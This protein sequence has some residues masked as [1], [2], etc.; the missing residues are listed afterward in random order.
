MRK[1]HYLFILFTALMMVSCANDDDY[2]PV[3]IEEE[4]PLTLLPLLSEMKIFTSNLSALTPA[5]GVQ[6]YEINSTLF[7]DYASKQRLIKLPEGKK[8]SYNS[9]SLLPDF[10][11]NTLIA[12]TFYYNL[13]DRNPSLGKKIIETRVFIKLDDTWIAGNY[14]WNASQTEATLRDTGSI[15]NISYI[16]AN[17]DTQTVDYQIPSTQ[18]CFTCHNNQAA[19]IPIGLKLRNLNFTPSYTS[20]N[21]LDYL[22]ANNLLEGVPSGSIAVLPDWTDDLNYS[23]EQRARAYM[24]VNC[25]HCHMPGGSVPPGFLLDFQLETPFDDTGIYTNRGEIVV[26]FGSTLASYRMP[27]LGRTVVHEPALQM[28]TDYMDSL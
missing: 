12:K 22:T 23:L 7:T 8:M 4:E 9:S 17:G 14:I 26:R 13:D 28:L 1:L 19:T 20:Q 16:D 15:E 18:D 10:P 5:Q 21:Q 27:Q 11:D 25:A 6:L 24:D 2:N 3:I